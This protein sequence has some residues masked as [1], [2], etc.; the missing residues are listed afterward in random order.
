M[1]PRCSGSSEGASRFESFGSGLGW[2]AEKRVPSAPA[3]RLLP[4]ERFWEARVPSRR[5][6]PFDDPRGYL[7]R[8]LR[9]PPTGGRS[10]LHRALDEARDHVSFRRILLPTPEEIAQGQPP[11]LEAFMAL[12]ASQARAEGWAPRRRGR[13]AGE[14]GPEASFAR[15]LLRWALRELP[16][17]L[18]PLEVMALAVIAGVQTVPPRF[19]TR[20]G[21][22]RRDQRELVKARWRV[23]CRAA[24]ARLDSERAAG[25]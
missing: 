1:V 19:E 24:E 9:W 23:A 4:W 18:E 25:A 6:D 22:N 13:P 11:L 20:A 10:Y 16:E 3:P 15:S 5:P 21:S 17:P 7:A 2:P 12:R 14:I 8:W